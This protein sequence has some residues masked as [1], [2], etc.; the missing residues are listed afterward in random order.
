MV[1]ELFP[2]SLD[3]GYRGHKAALWLFGL[4][5]ALKLTQSVTS[6]VAAREIA[7]NADGIAIDSFPP[8]AAQA[9]VGLFALRSVWRLLVSLGGVLALVRYRRAI[10]LFFAVMLLEYLLSATVLHFLPITA[11][12]PPGPMINLAAFAVMVVGFM[13]S[14]WNRGAPASETIP[15]G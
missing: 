8:A 3:N 4:V 14:L 2:K 15:E 9:V 1:S 10:P 6:I 13:L 5:V 11:G 7:T 12:S